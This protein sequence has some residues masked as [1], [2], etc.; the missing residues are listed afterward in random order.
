MKNKK[1]I[2]W[3]NGRKLIEE[4]KEKHEKRKNEQNNKVQGRPR[5]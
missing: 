3:I 2:F 5:K 4:L 1:N